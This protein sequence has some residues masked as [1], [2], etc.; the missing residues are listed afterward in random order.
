VLGAAGGALAARAGI[1]VALGRTVSPGSARL[2]GA[3]GLGSRG[4][5]RA[6]LGALSHANQI[7]ILLGG[8]ATGVF[9]RASVSCTFRCG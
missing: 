3:S 7:T 1:A 2:V 6:G 5:V 9:E 4:L 8:L